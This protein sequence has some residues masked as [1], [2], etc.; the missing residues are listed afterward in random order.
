VAADRPDR[1]GDAGSV[2]TAPRAAAI[3][4]CASSG[5]V[6][7]L[8]PLLAELGPDSPPV[9]AVL[10]LPRDRPSLL[11]AIFGRHCR[12]PV[13]EAVDQLPLQGGSVVFAPPDYHLLVERGPYVSLSVDPPVHFSRPSADVLFA[14]AA[15]VFGSGLLA[16]VLTGGNDDGAAGA[17]AVHRAGGRVVVQDPAEARA[18][19]MPAAAL[20][21][22]PAAQ[23]MTLDEIGRL[24]RAARSE[25]R[26]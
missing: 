14:S 3:V 9:L 21:R 4:A 26:T 19:D 17:E 8:L 18:P 25:E 1:D 22:V 6:E 24:L 23:K 20:A 15:D 5:G 12:V 13:L 10:H 16:I 2:D 11:T 7:A